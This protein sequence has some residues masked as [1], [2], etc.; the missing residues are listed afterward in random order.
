MRSAHPLAWAALLGFVCILPIL[1]Y[2]PFL[3]EPFNNDEGFYAAVAQLVLHGGLPYRDAFDNKPPAVF[4]WYALS[5]LMFGEHV[6]APRLLVSALVSLTVPLIYLEGRL[7]FSSR[8][9]LIAAF[10]FAVSIGLARFD[11]NANT[12]YFMLL[13]MT[14]GLVAFTLGQQRCSLWWY[15]L[16][17]V[18]SGV[19]I[20]TK[21][22]SL[23]PFAF[24]LAWVLVPGFRA[25]PARPEAVRAAAVLAAGCAVAVAGL[26][27]PFVVLGAFGDFWDVAVVYTFAYVGHAPLGARV[28]F[29][30]LAVLIPSIVAG[31]WVLLSLLALGRASR[32]RDRVIWFVVGWLFASGLGIVSAGQYFWHYNVQLLPGLSLLA[33]LGF[34]ALARRFRTSAPRAIA[35]ALLLAIASL[36]ALAFS[37]NVYLRQ[38]PSARHEAKFGHALLTGWETQSPA[39]GQYLADHTQPAD[40]IYNLGFQ[41]EL[42]FYADRRSPTRYMFDRPLEID[43]SLVDDAL[44]DL[45]Q[46]MPA[47]IVDSARYETYKTP[48]YDRSRFEMFF[49]EHYEYLGKIYYADVYRLKSPPG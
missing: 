48:Q 28:G 3:T 15:A 21:E 27:A 12:E 11:T 25:R 45:A 37:F 19:A 8:T 26:I 29:L 16:S 14:A 5:F 30:L 34:A 43:N 17:G 10:A 24:L 36:G 33:P 35:P 22:T 32:D 1:L 47:Y 18:C 7:L 42:Y 23:F 13:P 46:R 49:A 39:L 9:G 4:G 38:T 41:S 40:Y 6:W 44:R 20:M 2:L 31:P